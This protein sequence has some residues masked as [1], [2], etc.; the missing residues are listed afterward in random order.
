M[1]TVVIEPV[2]EMLERTRLPQP[3]EFNITARRHSVRVQVC[4]CTI[5]A[6]LI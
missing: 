6:V 5:G 1:I 3:N 2:S 4:T